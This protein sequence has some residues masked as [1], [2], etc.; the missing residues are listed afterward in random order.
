ML[1]AEG[2]PLTTDIFDL[3]NVNGQTFRKMK[4]VDKVA[5]LLVLTL[6][7]WKAYN[8]TDRN[9][10]LVLASVATARAYYV[11]K[12]GDSRPICVTQLIIGKRSLIF[13]F[14]AFLIKQIILSERSKQL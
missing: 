13:E 8:N 5:N 7:C 6:Y 4:S 9:E 1:V 14:F 10:L 2:Y 12:V 3:N 11:A